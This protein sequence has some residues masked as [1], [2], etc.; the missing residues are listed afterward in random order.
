MVG[1]HRHAPQVLARRRQGRCRIADQ[2]RM[3]HRIFP[4]PRRQTKPCPIIKRPPGTK[5]V[6][7]GAERRPRPAPTEDAARRWFIRGQNNLLAMQDTPAF[8]RH[9]RRHR[10]AEHDI[11]HRAPVAHGLSRQ[12]A[13]QLRTD[14][15]HSLTRQERRPHREIFQIAGKQA[16]ARPQ[17]RIQQHPAEKRT[18]QTV[19]KV[20]AEPAGSQ[21]RLRRDIRPRARSQDPRHQTEQ[22]PLVRHAQHPSSQR[23]ENRQRTP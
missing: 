13:D 18:R 15:T 8:Q 20:L 16:A 9:P 11:L 12:M 1:Q 19:E 2:R 21:Q 6:H 23:A 14:G 17:R 7:R 10:A 3:Q 4:P 22:T 5:V